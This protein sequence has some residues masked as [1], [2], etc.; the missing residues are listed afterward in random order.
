MSK[1]FLEVAGDL[2]TAKHH[3]QSDLIAELFH[4]LEYMFQNAC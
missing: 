1:S 4:C 3:A 2:G